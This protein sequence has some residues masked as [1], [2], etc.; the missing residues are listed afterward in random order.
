VN[1]LDKRIIIVTGKGGTGKTTVAA[2]LG[3][4]AARSG[5]QTLI[6]ETHGTQRICAMFGRTPGDY[7]PVPIHPGLSAMSITSTEAIEDYVVQQIKVR[8][9]Y[10]LVF[11]NRVMGPFMDAVPGLHDAVHLGKVFDLVRETKRD[12]EPAWDLVIVDAP[13]TGHGLHMFGA[14]RSIMELTRAGPVYEGVKLVDEVIGDADQTALVLTCL[15][16]EMPVSETLDLCARL[17]DRRAQIA[18]CVLNEVAE[19]PLSTMADWQPARE[20]LLE[21][22]DPA[23]LEATALTQQWV[24]RVQ[25]QDRFR[26]VLRE[27]LSAPVFDLPLQPQ[28]ALGFTELNLLSRALGSHLVPQ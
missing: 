15:P 21:S 26:E 20:V 19:P 2:A 8:Q 18:A 16:E 5:K 4:W 3:L 23:V 17:G 12:G 7:T 11:R 9:L 6:C 14:P 10:K 25:R 13:A 24:D 28:R 1:L 22:Q 27:G